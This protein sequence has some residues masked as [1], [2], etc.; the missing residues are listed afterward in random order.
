MASNSFLDKYRSNLNGP[1]SDNSQ[2]RP[3]YASTQPQTSQYYSN[4]AD[5]SAL[6]ASGNAIQD[7][8]FGNEILSRAGP[9]Q[10]YQ[11][12]SY[13]THEI[14][15]P[16]GRMDNLSVQVDH[17]PLHVVKPSEQNIHYKQQ[18][19]VRFL[20]PPPGPEPAPII[21]KERHAPHPPAPAPVVIRQRPATPPTPPPLI[22]RERP[23][24]PPVQQQPQIIEKILP[25]PPAPARQVIVERLPQPPPKPRQVIYEKWL[26]YQE[27]KERP[28]I[29]QRAPAP[30]VIR[31][32]KNVIIQHEQ[33]KA[34]HEQIITD[35]GV[36]HADPQYHNATS[37]IGEVRIVDKITDLPVNYSKYLT[38]RRPETVQSRAPSTA[39]QYQPAPQ[40]FTQA[41]P[42]PEYRSTNYNYPGA[43]TTTYRASYTNQNQNRS[44]YGQTSGN[45]ASQA[46]VYT[47]YV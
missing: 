29:V 34:H 17:E 42:G 24:T 32:P 11:H 19:N 27:T 21:I 8:R 20:Q 30:E 47:K 28:V 43:Y 26:P 33:P 15:A 44:G 31:P 5:M 12:P 1:G 38:N 16:G 23:P 46:A 39:S 6:R 37:T 7:E 41:E 18:V 13:R 25:P 3:N 36:F 45:D 40:Q 10:H 9:S 4:N 35:E 2:S 22:I 14:I